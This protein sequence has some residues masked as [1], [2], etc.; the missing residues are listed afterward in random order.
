MVYLFYCC[1][2]LRSLHPNYQNKVYVGSTP[3]PIKRLR[4][5]NGDLTQGAYK[6]EKRR[7]WEMVLFVYGFPSQQ[8][9]L[10]FEWAWQH[11]TKSRH[12]KRQC[13]YETAQSKLGPPAHA[14][15]YFTKLR[16]LYDLLCTKPFTRWP[17][18]IHFMT[19]SHQVLFLTEAPSGCLTNLPS[20]LYLS[21]GPMQ[22]LISFIDPSDSDDPSAGWFDDLP[23]DI[24]CHVCRLAMNK[25]AT[26]RYVCCPGNYSQ[27]CIM[28]AHLTCLANLFLSNDVSCNLIPVEGQCPACATRLVWGD[29]IYDMQLRKIRYNSSIAND[30]NNNDEI[31]KD[32]DDGSGGANNHDLNDNDTT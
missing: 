20:Q 4:Q 15:L 27:S 13:I 7:P 6:T 30:D 26:D 24:D 2:L 17:L 28:V 12:T 9:A 11:P 3:D 31:N 5:H 1:Y 32:N 10:Q 14:N 8:S 16:A 19:L 23:N 21:N 25:K 22:D 18:K 29:L